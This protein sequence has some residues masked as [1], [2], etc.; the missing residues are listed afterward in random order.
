MRFFPKLQRAILAENSLHQVWLVRLPAWNWFWNGQP[1]HQHAFLRF[2]DDCARPEDSIH[3]DNWKATSD[4]QWAAADAVL[5]GVVGKTGKGKRPE[6]V[7]ERARKRVSGQYFKLCNNYELTANNFTIY[8]KSTL[9]CI[10]RAA[11]SVRMLVVAHLLAFDRC[12]HPLRNVT[13]H[14]VYNSLCRGKN[15]YSTA[16]CCSLQWKHFFLFASAR[17]WGK[18]C[19]WSANAA[20]LTPQWLLFYGNF[21]DDPAC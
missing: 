14:C 6:S 12:T 11:R 9:K 20:P 1:E 7:S 10:R 2:S 13:A 3:Q 8:V 18:E 19:A 17:L 16:N 21:Y 4:M 15:K 5:V